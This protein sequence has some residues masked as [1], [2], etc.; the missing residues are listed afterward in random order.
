MAGDE[1]QAEQV[2]L[3]IAVGRGGERGREVGK[4]ALLLFLQFAGELFMFA[5]EPRVAAKDVDGAMLGRGHEPCAGVV[6]NAGF[7]P[8]LKCGDQRI[9]RELFGDADIAHDASEAGDDAR[10]LHAPYGV[11][12]AI[13]LAAVNVSRSHGWFHRIGVSVR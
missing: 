8:L 9:L 4:G 6:R 3:D 13:D 11:D 2:V 1:D 7:R 10:R 12:G 5:L